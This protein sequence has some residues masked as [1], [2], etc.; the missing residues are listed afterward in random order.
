MIRA[1]DVGWTNRSFTIGQLLHWG[2]IRFHVS[3]C[4]K[5]ISPI[6]LPQS[7]QTVRSW[8][9]LSLDTAGDS[10]PV[11]A[12]EAVIKHRKH[13]LKHYLNLQLIYYGMLIMIC[14]H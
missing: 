6:F 9:Q 7:A 2:L 12:D 13:I 1:S 4:S 14:C 3:P 5:D 10:S 8:Q 11:P